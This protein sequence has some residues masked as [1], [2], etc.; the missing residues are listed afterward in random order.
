MSKSWA[1]AIAVLY[2][3]YCQ[4]CGSISQNRKLGTLWYPG[5]FM[6][7]NVTAC[8]LDML[9]PVYTLRK[10]RDT[11]WRVATYYIDALYSSGWVRIGD[12]SSLESYQTFTWG[13]IFGR[14]DKEIIKIAVVGGPTENTMQE[15]MIWEIQSQG[16]VLATNRNDYH[17]AIDMPA[18]LSSSPEYEIQLAH[19]LRKYEVQ[20]IQC[21]SSG[22]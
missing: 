4:G 21:L 22:K 1:I 18:S 16:K 3:L 2:S 15:I 5:A 11:V 10:D 7:N 8:D 20:V 13:G 12:L 9:K 17:A 14:S 6:T 19:D